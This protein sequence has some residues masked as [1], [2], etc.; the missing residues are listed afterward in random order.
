MQILPA[1]DLMN[2]RV[3]RLSKGDP[4]TAKRYD[5]LGDPVKIARQWEA[6]GADALHIIDL[7]AAFNVGNNSDMITEI[8][9]AINL[10]TQVGGGMRSYEYCR[11]MLELGIDRILL[12]T[13]A[14]REPQTLTRLQNEFGSNRILVALDNRNGKVLVEGWKAATEFELQEALKKFSN[15]NVNTFLITSTAKDGTMTGPDLVTLTEA[16]AYP[17]VSI[18]AAGGIGSLNH[19]AALR[20]IGA[21]GVVIGKAL[22]EGMFTLTDAL[23]IAE[24]R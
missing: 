1:I 21:E 22:Y 19:L 11:K 16:C 13:L 3:V 8:V 2:G 4:N 12:A 9:D 7:D 23:R 6:G 14:F 5:H 18:I 24:E 15:L 20:C 10:P 17:N